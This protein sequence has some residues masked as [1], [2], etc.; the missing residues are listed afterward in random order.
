V[1]SGGDAE[2]EQET[3]R[4]F[5]LG[6]N[7][8][9]GGL[10]MKLWLLVV[11]LC[12]TIAPGCASEERI[13][14]LL[15]SMVDGG[16]VPT[17]KAF[18]DTLD[19]EYVNQ[20]SPEGV[21]EF[22][23]WAAKLLADSRPDAQRYGLMCFFAVTTRRALDSEALLEP[24]VPNLLRIAS[25][26]ASPLQNMARFVL[27]NTYPRISPKTLEYMAAHLIDKDNTPAETGAMACALLRDG[28]D[29]RT[30]DVIA[31]VRNQ[32]KP[33]VT[34]EVLKCFRIL[35]PT[36]NADA[37]AFVGSNLDSSDASVR[38]SAVEVVGRLPLVERSPFL[39][40]L[41]RL[42]TDPNEPAEIRSA[43]AEALK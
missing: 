33:E 22:L 30:H 14:V 11:G 29:A 25:D 15:R 42:A 7:L 36:N 23:P 21:S 20:L 18:Y 37:L 38:R 34:G 10:Q 13:S 40:R 16:P 27:G 31:F 17:E 1:D 28:S 5:G 32:D 8:S 9:D 2:K 39:A 19:E 43:A 41:S 4:G 35:P 12:L 3:A 26:R 24:Y 6:Y